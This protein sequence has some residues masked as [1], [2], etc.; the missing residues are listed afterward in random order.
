MTKIDAK[1]YAIGKLVAYVLTDE[2]QS[3][4][5]YS[6]VAV[7]FQNGSNVQQFHRIMLNNTIDYGK[8]YSRSKCRNN[9]IC[10]YLSEDNSC[11]YGTII[12][13]FLAQQMQ[14][15]CLIKKLHA[16]NDSSPLENIRPSRNSN[17][18]LLNAQHLISQQVVHI[19]KFPI[20]LPINRI[21]KKCIF[22]SVG[23]NEYVIAFPNSYEI[24]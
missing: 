9:T 17:T 15:F 11:C 13:F 21:I 3:I 8:R 12:T 16:T 10:C 14:P 24:H 23:Q 19:S 7:N 2:E 6:D 20:A 18:S 22:I 4:I 5:V 1:C